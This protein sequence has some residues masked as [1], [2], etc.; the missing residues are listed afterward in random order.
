[1]FV[2]GLLAMYVDNPALFWQFIICIAPGFVF[3]VMYGLLVQSRELNGKKAPPWQ[4]FKVFSLTNIASILWT[5]Y[6]F[7]WP[8]ADMTAG[9][10]AL[11]VG[12]YALVL[13][14]PILGGMMA[15]LWLMNAYWF[16]Q[17]TAHQLRIW[18]LNH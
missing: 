13:S 3:G 14:F 2:E 7:D 8:F 16:L 11:S 17:R 1:M 15:G 6:I 5:G 12:L 4:M 9:I 18:N 10:I